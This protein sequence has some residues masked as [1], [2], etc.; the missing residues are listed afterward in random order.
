M[1]PIDK[2]KVTPLMVYALIEEKNNLEMSIWMINCASPEE[3]IMIGGSALPDPNYKS[4]L[5]KAMA[6]EIIEIEKQLSRLEITYRKP[7]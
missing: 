1:K 2:E 5:I 6:D 4:L 3:R 7:E